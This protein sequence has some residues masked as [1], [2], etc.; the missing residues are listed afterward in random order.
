M[1]S[2][3]FP[4]VHYSNKLDLSIIIFLYSKIR[5]IFRERTINTQEI[6]SFFERLPSISAHAFTLTSVCM[7]L[8]RSGRIGKGSGGRKDE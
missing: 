8:G 5:F 6:H 7:G 4:V 2:Q 3:K 1:K